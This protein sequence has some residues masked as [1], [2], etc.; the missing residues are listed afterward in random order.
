MK[1]AMVL[2][3]EEKCDGCGECITACAEGALKLVDGKAKIISDN[4]CDGFGVCLGDCPQGAISIQEREADAFDEDAV[5]KH[6]SERDAPLKQWPIK[7]GLLSPL[8]PMLK[9]SDFVLA[10]DCAAFA[11]SK[12]HENML[13][14]RPFAIACP[15]LD[16]PHRNI[17]RLTDIFKAARPKSITIL[18][19]EVPCCGGL[20][21]MAKMAMERAG[22]DI[23]LESEVIGIGPAFGGMGKAMGGG[24]PSTQGGCPST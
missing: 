9:N 7:L 22:V 16:E 13:K 8:A 11:N 14:D 6:L 12:F 21:M 10:A 1:R 5:K 24:C 18:R 20:E 15:K 4:L 17:D 2:I 3:D 19:M 23:P